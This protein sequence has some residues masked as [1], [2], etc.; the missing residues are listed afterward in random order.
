MLGGI[1][2]GLFL[3]SFGGF[4]GLWLLPQDG[5]ATGATPVDF[6]G[7]IYIRKLTNPRLSA[8]LTAQSAPPSLKE[9]GGSRCQSSKYAQVTAD[10]FKI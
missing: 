10:E 6:M 2:N 1:N 7:G 3:Q 5:Q 9:P 8:W 4:I